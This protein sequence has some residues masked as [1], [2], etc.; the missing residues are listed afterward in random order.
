MAKSPVSV[1]YTSDSVEIGVKDGLSLPADARGFLGVG[2]DGT[3]TRFFRVNSSGQQIF[4]GAGSAGSPSGGVVSIQGVSG[5]TEVPISGTVTIQDGGGSITVDG[6]VTANQG[7]APWSV[8]DGGSS[9]TV[10]TSQLPAALVG[11]RLDADIGAWLGSTAPTVG[12]KAMASSVPVAI[13]SD[14]SAIPVSQSGTWT[15]QQGTPPWAVKGTDADGSP[16]TQNPVL[17]AG[18]DGT[19]VQSLKTETDGTARVKDAFIDD[20]NKLVDVNFAYDG[21]TT[22][23]YF[24]FVDLNGA[25]YKHQSGTAIKVA[26]VGGRALKSVIG[27]KWE[28]ALMVVLRID[29]TDS[30]LGVLP[31]GSVSLRDTSAFSDGS[32]L[33]L[34]PVLADLT[35]SGGDFTKIANGAKETNVTAVNT[36]V[37]FKDV[38]GNNVTPSVGD[39][40]LRAT[41]LSGSGDLEFAYG[42]S[43]FVE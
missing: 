4:V 22:T 36:G 3:N 29:G 42:M 39:L 17:I 20:R 26:A 31:I 34:F 6:A 15:I 40:L 25:Q 14:Q 9:I 1:P 35:V 10:D 38:F 11:G 43:Y 41:L 13:S 12:Q 30:D 8:S 19:N 18:Q 23:T 7:G 24:V 32:T 33:I 2:Y 16:P 5:G 27:S 28:V 21:V 37:T